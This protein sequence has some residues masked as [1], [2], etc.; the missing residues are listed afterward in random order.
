MPPGKMS[1]QNLHKADQQYD[2]AIPKTSS[3]SQKH[4]KLKQK[5]NLT[6]AEFEAMREAQAHCC[7][8]CGEPF[9]TG[10]RAVSVD[11]NHSTGMVRDLLCGSCN[12]TIGFSKENPA[13]LRA[14]AAYLE[15]HGGKKRTAWH[16]KKRYRRYYAVKEIPRDAQ[17]DIGR[18]RFT[19]SLK[20]SDLTIANR[21]A[22]L[23][24]KKWDG[25]IEKVRWGGRYAED[26]ASF[27]QSCTPVV[28][29]SRLEPSLQAQSQSVASP[30]G[31]GDSIKL[32]EYLA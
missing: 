11:H 7:A 21:R 17:A 16:I 4:H 13:R 3:E 1:S 18:K 23:L 22:A 31:E 10:P 8:S 9:T 5:Y 19:A 14:A 25:M 20:T 2:D 26:E 30:R 32:T 15:R 29:P 12:S 6:Y 24:V 27:V 28:Y